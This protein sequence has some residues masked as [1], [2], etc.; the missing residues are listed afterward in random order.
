MQV[1]K[2]AF[3]SIEIMRFLI[4]SA[5]GVLFFLV[6]FP[7]DGT[8][9]TVLGIVIDWGKEALKPIL[10]VTAMTLVV[11]S[12]I[13]TIYASLFK[14]SFIMKSQ[15]FKDLFVVSPLW[16]I[17][18][19]LGAIFSVMVYYKI[20]PEAIWSMDTGGTPVLVLAPS[21]LVIFSVLAAA[22]SLLTD[23]GL[24]EYVGTLARPLMHP[25]FTL[26]GR[27]AIDTLASWLG[28]SSVGVAITTRLH[29]EG[30]YSDREAAIIS[31]S[32]SILSVAYI[33]VMADFVG[34]PNMYFQILITIYAVSFILAI[35]APRFWPLKGIP[36]SYSGR[37]GK[38]RP[39]AEIPPDHTLHSWALKTAVERANREGIHTVARTCYQTF[40]FLIVSTMP[41]VVSWGTIVLIIATYTPI[42]QWISLPF[43]YMLELVKIPEAYKVA[44]AFVLAFADQFLAAVIGATCTTVA[45]KFMCACI[46]ATGLIYMTEIGV[47]ILNSSIP[48][49]F[50]KLTAIYFMRAVLSVFLLAPFVWLFC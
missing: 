23:F 14:P 43:A 13:I 24:M 35:L 6:P 12:A 44:P 20:G 49:D 30:Y 10:V 47:L 41:L 11:A 16:S 42:F 37:S 19:I 3:S 18:R 7:Q 26:P 38:Q 39:E 31:T 22:V 28:S 32:F 34:L 29:D 27:S 17:S 48:L 33:Y 9:N 1:R 4:P 50:P 5:L 21:L 15:F 2:Q 40:C 8:F 45:A 46:S 25:L 36:D